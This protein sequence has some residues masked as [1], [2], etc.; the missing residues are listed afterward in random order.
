MNTALKYISLGIVGVALASCCGYDNN[1]SKGY[2][3][4][5]KTKTTFEEK[6]VTFS[7]GGKNAVPYTKVVK[8]PTT[9][10]YTV[11]EKCV[12]TDSYTPR[13]DCCGV[14]S[15]EV[16]KRATTQGGTGEPFLGLIPTMKPLVL[17]DN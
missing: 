15:K 1:Y 13:P 12:C 9:E 6:V 10:T 14:L 3:N 2:K 17:K 7:P 4:I 11:K 8:V 5:E 16:I